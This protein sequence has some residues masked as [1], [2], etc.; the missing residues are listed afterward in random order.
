MEYL[1]LGVPRDASPRL[2]AIQYAQLAIV[3]LTGVATFLAAVIPHSSKAFTFSLLYSLIL[4]S[5]T[6]TFLV[7]KE[8]AA[9]KK[10][11]LSKDKYVKYQLF[12]IIAAAGLYVVG[13]I[14]FAMTRAGPQKSLFPGDSG[15]LMNGYIVNRWQGWILWL[16]VFNWYVVLP[17]SLSLGTRW[18]V[19]NT[20]LFRIFLWASLFY[21][22]CMTGKKQG[23]I[24]LEGEEANIGIEDDEALAR[25]IQAQDPN[26]QA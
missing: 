4:S 16:S 11:M 18:S 19:A 24:A 3:I 1:R 12:K 5:F 8:Q 13:F 14:G 9:A 23:A 7:R 21:S 20:W 15:L 22:C 17:F 10:G 6:T 26:W 25:R 2:K